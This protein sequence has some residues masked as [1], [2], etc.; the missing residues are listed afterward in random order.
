MQPQNNSSSTLWKRL[1][2]GEMGMSLTAMVGMD[3][4][5]ARSTE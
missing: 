4:C 5:H 3:M 2:L 1:S